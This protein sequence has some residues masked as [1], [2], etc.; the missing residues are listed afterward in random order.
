MISGLDFKNICKWNLCNRYPINFIPTEVEEN[1][2]VFLNLDNI[3]EFI[4][5]LKRNFLKKKF[6]LITHNSD[7]S[8]DEKMF[9]ELNPYI[10]NF[11][12]L[13]SLISNQ[14]VKKIPL[15][16]ID[17][18]LE[19]IKNNS[20]IFNKENLI[21]L[22]F[23]IPNH[24]DRKNC[25]DFFSDKNW[26]FIRNIQN[27]RLPFQGYF[28]ELNTFKYSLCPRG[29]GIDTHR[30]YESIFL[31]TIPIVNRNELSDLY[32]KLPVFLIDDWKEITYDLLINNYKHLYNNI[33]K[34][35]E[36]NKNWIETDFWIKN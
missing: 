30:I 16:F 32:E 5:F 29:T 31:N 6:S 1:D 12:C 4:S 20:I 11:Y 8:F 15:G 22:N 35:K 24:I 19:I 33:I 28:N 21:Y 36:E 17:N 23:H 27:E 3:Y 10:N 14:K 9:N 34:W 25:F 18:K 2:L 26:C 13:N 7:L